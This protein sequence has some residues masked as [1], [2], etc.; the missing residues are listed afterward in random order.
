MQVSIKC[1]TMR[2]SFFGMILL[3]ALVLGATEAQAGGT[4]PPYPPVRG[5]AWNPNPNLVLSQGAWWARAFRWDSVTGQT[6]DAYPNDLSNYGIWAG[7]GLVRLGAWDTT[8]WDTINNAAWVTLTHTPLRMSQTPAV[9]LTGKVSNMGSTPSLGAAWTGIKFDAWF[10]D[11]G[12]NGR[13]IYMELYFKRTG[14][15][16]GIAWCTDLTA[17][18]Q[19]CN[20][21][22]VRTL[23]LGTLDDYM[24]GLEG[25]RGNTCVLGN[26]L[27]DLVE[28]VAN[29]DG[30]TTFRVD[31][32]AMAGR[33]AGY[34]H[35]S[36]SGLELYEVG[37]T[38]ESG[39][40]GPGD[41]GAVWVD[42]NQLQITYD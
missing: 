1:C 30:S 31:L 23:S 19:N 26:C 41:A 20:Y 16:E 34:F 3:S 35:T 2:R 28:I 10:N 8:W 4:P 13:K 24:V 9:T 38:L 15:N 25:F 36:L 18:E 40:I 14:V 32:K 17:I 12:R 5:N 7:N 42:I 21:E 29:A 22:L 6:W 27:P 33:A 37:A 11:T 39:E